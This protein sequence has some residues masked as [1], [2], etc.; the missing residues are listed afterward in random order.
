[1]K[2]SHPAQPVKDPRLWIAGLV[3]SLRV[4]DPTEVP[5]WTQSSNTAWKKDQWVE[6]FRS[7]VLLR[8]QSTASFPTVIPVQD[9][10]K[11]ETTVLWGSEVRAQPF[12]VSLGVTAFSRRGLFSSLSIKGNFLCLL[13]DLLGSHDPLSLFSFSHLVED[14]PS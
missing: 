1:M 6:A 11:G 4:L 2:G 14:C 7:L 13:S 3:L 10:E 12:L 9:L 5:A 8:F